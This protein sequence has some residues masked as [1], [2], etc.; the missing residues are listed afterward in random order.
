[1]IISNRKRIWYIRYIPDGCLLAAM[2]AVLSGCIVTTVT[3]AESYDAIATAHYSQQ[4]EQ[5]LSAEVL[6]PN[7]RWPC[8]RLGESKISFFPPKRSANV[9]A[10]GPIVPILPAP[11]KGTDYG[12]SLFFV[13]I[14][15]HPGPSSFVILDPTK[16][17][18]TIQDSAGSL[19]P[20]I[21]EDCYGNPASKTELR[22]YGTN[23][24]YVLFYGISRGEVE[25]FTLMPASIEADD[26]LYMFPD[27][28]WGPDSYV[29]VE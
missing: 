3:E 5:A 11:G 26:I 7:C 13:G 1:M 28:D 10:V 25:R 4:P 8:Y 6:D 9:K 21:V 15:V 29:W 12:D 17:L 2:T 23:H 27:V 24:C 16:Y 14:H 18:V 22:V 20:I 19:A